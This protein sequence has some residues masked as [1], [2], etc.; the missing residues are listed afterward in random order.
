MGGAGLQNACGS[1]AGI[2]SPMFTG[3]IVQQTGSFAMAFVGAGIA[4]LAGAASFGLQVGDKPMDG[5]LLTAKVGEQKAGA[6]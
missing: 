5:L 2:V 6:A 3:W 1:L 4:C